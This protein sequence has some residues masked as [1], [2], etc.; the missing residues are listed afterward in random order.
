MIVLCYK[1][2]TTCKKIEGVSEKELIE[3]LSRNGMMV[4]RPLVVKGDLILVGF[5]EM[6]WQ[7]KLL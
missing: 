5:N 4:K 2:C 3:I 6:E 7:E 1:K